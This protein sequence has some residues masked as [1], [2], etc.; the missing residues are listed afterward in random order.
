MRIDVSRA[1]AWLGDQE[2]RSTKKKLD[3][4]LPPREFS[5]LVALARRGRLEE[6]EAMQRDAIAQF[7]RMSQAA[8]VHEATVYLAE[9]LLWRGDPEAAIA[10]AREVTT[11]EGASANARAIANAALAR[12]LLVGGRPDAAL[13]AAGAAV[14]GIARAEEGVG[15]IWVAYADALTAVGRGEESCEVVAR[16]AAGLSDR[17]GL[18]GDEEMRAAFLAVPEHARLLTLNVGFRDKT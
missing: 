17:A 9:T 4:R 12:A 3:P 8:M 6:A 7:R 2:L 15:L 5:F 11:D 10:A 1:R 14:E 16:A 13:E 18:I